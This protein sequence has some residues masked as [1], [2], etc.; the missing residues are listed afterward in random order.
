[1]QFIVQ[2]YPVHCATGGRAFDPSGGQTPLLFIHGAAMDGSVWQWQ[3]RAFAHRGYRVL[4]PDLPAHG[5]SPGTPRHE[6][7]ALSSWIV[8]LMDAA[9]IERAVLIGHS[10]G[11]LVTLE[12]A[13]RY[14]DRVSA[15]AVLGCALPMPVGAAFLAAA[16]NS[17]AAGVL[18]QTV[19]SHA[20]GSCLGASPTPGTCLAMASRATIASAD[21]GVQYAGLHACNAYERTLADVGAL[22]CP[23]Q[24]IAGQRDLMTPMKAGRALADAIAGARFA[25]LDAGHSLM[26]ERPREVTQTLASFLLAAGLTDRSG[27]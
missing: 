12:T 1:M 11:S 21:P 7:A 10:L 8:A 3:A 14:P 16:Q 18:M 25:S 4:A 26:S 17:S 22:T 19:W 27:R 20:P 23:T 6:V 2:G 13:M 9:N 24:V 5:R 15:V